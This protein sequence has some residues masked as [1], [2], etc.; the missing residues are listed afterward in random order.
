MV[1]APA[2]Q[3]RKHDKDSAVGGIHPAEM[4]ELLQG[5]DDAVESQNQG[6][7]EA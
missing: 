1:Y 3:H 5:R 2:P 6:S 7:G 4:W